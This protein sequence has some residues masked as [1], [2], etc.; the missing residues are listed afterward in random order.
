MS[1][2]T[3]VLLIDTSGQRLGLAIATPDKVWVHD[4]PLARGHAEI[5]FGRIAQLLARA[6][7]AYPDL[8]RL[9]VTVGPGSFTGLRIGIAAARGLGLA[10][11]VTVLGI[12]NLLAMSLEGPDKRFRVVADARR[13]K[14]FVQDF[15]GPGLPVGLPAMV[16]AEDAGLRADNLQLV[17]DTEI[18]LK[19]VAQFAQSAQ[20]E[21]FPP[22]PVYVRPADAKPQTKGRVA[23]A[24]EAAP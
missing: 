8:S 4:E 24:G 23:R 20:P 12:P 15:A 16:A 3:T 2:T 10:L 1:N 11:G 18:D 5:I 7:L 9:A 14:S 17:T 22:E 19:R 21:Q 6:G 13:G